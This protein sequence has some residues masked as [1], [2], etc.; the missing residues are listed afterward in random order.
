MAC[1]EICGG[2][3]GGACQEGVC[4]SER[5]A[6]GDADNRAAGKMSLN[7]GLVAFFSFGLFP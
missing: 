4:G 3:R 6:V 2:C 1:F 5:D 7:G